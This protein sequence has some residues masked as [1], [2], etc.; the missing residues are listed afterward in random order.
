MSDELNITAE[1]VIETLRQ[2][3]KGQEDFRYHDLY[4]TDGVGGSA[5]RYV[6]A[7]C[8]ACL[9]GRVLHILGFTI[10]E[11]ND[12]DHQSTSRKDYGSLSI[13]HS[14]LPGRVTISAKAV[15]VLQ[16]A[17]TEQDANN[18]WGAALLTAEDQYANITEG[19]NA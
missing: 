6:V 1:Q 15:I 12:M 14:R 10:A 9:V 2:V 3:V 17:Q 19:T 4:D 16:A 5:C 7:G 13:M 18:M 8:V 11:L